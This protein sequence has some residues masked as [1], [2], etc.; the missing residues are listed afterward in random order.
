[1]PM[2]FH[3]TRS[4]VLVVLWK[5]M[6]IFPQPSASTP[7]EAPTTDDPSPQINRG[8]VTRAVP[9]SFPYS[10]RNVIARFHAILLAQAFIFLVIPEALVVSFSGYRLLRG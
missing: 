8:V 6:G 1:M 5:S 4:V 3:N 7:M 10:T 9:R 2:L